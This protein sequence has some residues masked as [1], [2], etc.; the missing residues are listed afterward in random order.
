VT[1]ADDVLA[2]LD[3]VEGVAWSAAVADAATGRLLAV[4][5]PDLVLPTASI[6]KLLLLHEAAARM[7]DGRLDPDERLAR[8]PDDAV[9]DSGLW[10]HLRL[11]AI[12]AEDAALLVAS[13]S[14]NLATNVLLRRIGLDA[15][16][17][18][19]GRLGVPTVRLLDRVRD[20]R[21]PADPPRLSEGSALDLVR[22][23]GML[24][25]DEAPEWSLLRHWLSTG[26]D[27]SMVASGLGLDPLAHVDGDRGLRVLNKTG[28]DAGVRADVGIVGLG[29]RVVAYA[30]LASWTP[31][32]PDDPVRDDVLDVMRAV[33]RA[34]RGLDS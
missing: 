23:A 15:V 6:G 26:V 29:R 18:V 7:L 9:A 33:G 25:A 4:R 8:T 1:G 16:A 2:P 19:P 17:E 22:L 10:Q 24:A 31:Q 21:T 30:V 27:L 28:T 20:V 13:V 5:H 11:G 3:A 14:D 34:L 32:Q 12:P